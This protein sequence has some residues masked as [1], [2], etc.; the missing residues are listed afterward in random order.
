MIDA[1]RPARP[2]SKSSQPLTHRSTRSLHS[3]RRRRRSPAETR[4]G[5]SAHRNRAAWSS[6][7]RAARH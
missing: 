4:H 6:T 5:K 2:R 3:P 7:S 1:E